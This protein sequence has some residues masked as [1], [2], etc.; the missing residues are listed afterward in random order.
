M[1]SPLSGE[2]LPAPRG[3][4][5]VFFEIF[6]VFLKLGLTSFGGPAAHLGYFRNEFVAKRQWLSEQSFAGIVALCQ[7]LPGP[8]SSQTG[9]A[10]GLSRGGFM[11]AGAAWLGFTLPSAL[12]MLG[13]AYGADLLQGE[14]G[15]GVIH[16]L[17][18]V[19][20]AVVANAVWNMAKIFCADWPGALI[21]LAAGSLL[22]LTALPYAQIAVI[23]GG[24]MAGLLF[25]RTEARTRPEPLPF[26][27]SPRAGLFFCVV[28]SA[29]LLGLPLLAMQTHEPIFA[30]IN[31]F[32]RSGALV[33]GGG[34]VVLPLLQ[35]ELVKPGWIDGSYFLAGYGAAQALPGPLFT[36]AAYL[37]AMANQ[38][39]NGAGGAA[40]ALLSIF[41]PGLLLLAGVLP[42]WDR[43]R[44]VAGAAS[45]MR[46]VN[47]AVVGILG[48]ALYLPL[49]PSTIETPRDVSFAIGFFVLLTLL[50]APA[51]SVVMLGAATAFLKF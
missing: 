12:L 24:A 1:N 17:K 19:A 43:L 32:Y 46:G 39:P 21:A 26:S 27:I 47:A 4:V 22:V 11:G 44:Q 2:V 40:I 20:V 50:R 35:T 25:C 33:F 34:H 10:I 23:A 16:G 41:A 42:F 48:A 13:L 3:R 15:I 31:A 36:I 14:A 8:G 38:P 45:A 30:F 6:C 29:L 9:F 7:F 5:A 18:L 51:W 28:F 37:G 49:W